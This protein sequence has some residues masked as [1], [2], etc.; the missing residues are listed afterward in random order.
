MAAKRQRQSRP[1]LRSVAPDEKPPAEPEK[2]LT[3]TEAAEHGTRKDMLLALQS[4]IALTIESPSCP[5]RDLAS[6]SRRLIE[7]GEEL[8]G[9]RA[10]EREEAGGAAKT[11]DEEYRAG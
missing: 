10:A 3:I 7:V 2:R 5:P 1:P 8:D 4:R 6:L 9:I 11:P